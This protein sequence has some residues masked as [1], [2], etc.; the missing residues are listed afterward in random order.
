[1]S[2]VRKLVHGVSDQLHAELDLAR[3]FFADLQGKMVTPPIQEKASPAEY[4][5]DHASI[6]VDL[7]QMRKDGEHDLEE[8]CE[9][10]VDNLSFHD[11][12]RPLNNAMFYA[13]LVPDPSL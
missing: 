1:M 4:Q 8:Q 11:G 7:S 9:I 13:L 3:S 12:F 10:A 5:F 6:D 2:I